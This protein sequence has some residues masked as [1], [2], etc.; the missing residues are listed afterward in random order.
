MILLN[1]IRKNIS[2]AVIGLVA[3]VILLSIAGCQAGLNVTEGKK[4]FSSEVVNSYAQKVLLVINKN[5]ET[6][7]RVGRHYAALRKLSANQ[8][9]ELDYTE[10]RL[11]ISVAK[12]RET[13]LKPLVAHLNSHDLKEKIQFVAYST[14]FP[15]S[16]NFSAEF[17]GNY[18]N[19]SINAMTFLYKAVLENE[20][21]PPQKRYNALF[22]P[23][24]HALDSLQFESF[25]RKKDFLLST[26]L[27]V[28]E[29][30]SNHDQFNSEEEISIPPDCEF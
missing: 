29:N 23:Y 2:K 15:T 9:I 14:G 7:V 27:G 16:I 21:A 11:R 28:G 12:F 18:S 24:Y 19:A 30:N 8:V 13:I 6:S 17:A 20:T 1:S 25:D 26:L 4:K 3:L 5:D 10:N 22:N